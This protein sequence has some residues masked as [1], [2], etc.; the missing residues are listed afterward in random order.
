MIAFLKYFQIIKDQNVTWCKLNAIDYYPA[1]FILYF[2]PDCQFYT[3][4]VGKFGILVLFPL[5]KI[6]ALS[7]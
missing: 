6:G 3:K 5:L 1:C 2:L 7:F 4:N